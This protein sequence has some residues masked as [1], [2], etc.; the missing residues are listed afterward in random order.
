M[1]D[2]RVTLKQRALDDAKVAAASAKTAFCTDAADY[3]TAVDRYGDLLTQTKTTVGDVKDAGSDLEPTREDVVS[4]AEAAVS[5]NEAVVTAEEELSDAQ[6]TASPRASNSP[7]TSSSSQSVV[8]PPPASVT[9]VKQAET[10]FKSTQQGITDATPLHQAAQQFNAAAVALEMS[11]LALFADAGCL[12]SES[13][14]AAE[15]AVRDYTSALQQSLTD[16]GYY[17]GA[18]DGVYGP[19]TVAA[20]QALQK[21]H[22]LSMTGTVDKATDA[23]LRGDLQAKGGVAAQ[24]VLASTAAVQQTLKLAGYWN[25]PVDGEWTPE[26]TDAMKKFQTQL[27]VPATGTVDAATVAALE[28]AIAKVTSPNPSSTGPAGPVPSAGTPSGTATASP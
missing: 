12:T 26:L 14:R 20:V 4:S 11:W 24:Q 17:T 21:A 7:T 16:A 9:R 13:L 18:V 25:G 23:A 6:T 19:T 2:A 3:V 10:E 28:Q 1:A 5:A 27:G 22:G 15:K 8:P